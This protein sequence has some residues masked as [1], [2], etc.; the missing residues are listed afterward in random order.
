[1]LLTCLDHVF[2]FHVVFQVSP[3]LL[4]WI[5]PF[6]P[7]LVKVVPVYVLCHCLFVQG[8][9]A[10]P[11]DA[12]FYSSSLCVRVDLVDLVVNLLRQHAYG[13]GFCSL[14]LTVCQ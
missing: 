13:H 2:Y 3:A 7:H 11:K 5:F 12:R 6:F 8:K 1:M 10:G 14:R 4:S 9:D